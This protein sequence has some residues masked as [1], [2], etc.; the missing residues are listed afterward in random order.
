MRFDFK[1][2]RRKEGKQNNSLDSN[3]VSGTFLSIRR[4]FVDLQ[5]GRVRRGEHDVVDQQQA[6]IRRWQV[7]SQDPLLRPE[8]DGHALEG[9]VHHAAD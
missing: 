8:V 4:V 5:A 1:A 3:P 2:F 6:G 7:R 9:G